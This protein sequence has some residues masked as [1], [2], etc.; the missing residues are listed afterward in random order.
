[1]SRSIIVAALTAYT[2][3]TLGAFLDYAFKISSLPIAA[4]GLLLATL[5]LRSGMRPTRTEPATTPEK[6]SV[7]SDSGHLE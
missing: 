4:I 6:Q 7:Q 5:I 2:F 3:W 1:M